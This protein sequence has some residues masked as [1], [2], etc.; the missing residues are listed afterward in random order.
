M[1]WRHAYRATYG[2]VI[3]KFPADKRM[4]ESFYWR[5]Q[6]AEEAAEEKKEEGTT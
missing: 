1:N 5:G 6:D 4:V 2:S 3:E